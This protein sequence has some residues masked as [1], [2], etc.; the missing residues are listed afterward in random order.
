[1]AWHHFGRSVYLDRATLYRQSRQIHA[2][3]PGFDLH[4]HSTATGSTNSGHP[5]GLWVTLVLSVLHQ[6]VRKM[7]R[8][9]TRP[10]DLSVL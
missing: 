5:M 7:D 9:V 3:I 6:R 1:M 8:Q 10:T 4:T 2:G